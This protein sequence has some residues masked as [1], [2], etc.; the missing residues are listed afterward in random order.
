MTTATIQPPF[1]HSSGGTF[2]FYLNNIFEWR[3]GDDLHTLMKE[4]DKQKQT[5]WVW[6]V[7]GD[8]KSKYDIKWY[9]PQVEGA[10]VLTRVE[11]SKGKR[12]VN[13]GEE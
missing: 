12:V 10:F 1:R 13:K 3:T 6:Y 2:H 9:A 11:Y 5:Y 7:P 8:A 4:M